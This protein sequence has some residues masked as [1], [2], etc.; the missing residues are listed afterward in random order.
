VKILQLT[1][2]LAQSDTKGVM[3]ARLLELLWSIS[4]HAGPEASAHALESHALADILGH[5][6]SVN[7]ASKE[8]FMDRCLQMVTQGK[9]LINRCIQISH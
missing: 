2:K 9:A 3:A 1:K 6:A 8:A 5:Y 4:L 7:C